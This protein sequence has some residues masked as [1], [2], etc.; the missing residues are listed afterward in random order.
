MKR[1]TSRRHETLSLRGAAAVG[2][3]IGVLAATPALAQDDLRQMTVREAASALQ[4]GDITSSELVE[5]LTEAADANANL[6]AFITLDAAEARAAA[7]EADE[8]RARG[9]GEDMPL[10]GVPLVI[11]DNIIVAGQPTTGGTPALEGFVSERD[12][13]VIARLRDAGAIILGKTNMHELAFGITSD[14]ARFGAVGNAYDPER[15]AGGSSGG[16]GAAVAARLA[17]GGLGTDTG[18]SVRIP[19][20]LNGIAGLRPTMGRYSAAGIVPISHTRDTP[21][22]LARTVDDLV[23]LDGVITGTATELDPVDPSEIRLGIADSLVSGLS[24]EVAAVWNEA[25]AKL[26]GAGVTLVSVALPDLMEL[27]GKIGFPVALYEVARDLPAFLEQWDAGISLADVADQV[28]S[29]DVQGVFGTFV[30]GDKKMPEEVYRAAIETFRPE[31]QALYAETFTANRL[32]ALVFPTTILAAPPIE[33]SGETVEL[34]GEQV[35][36][37]PTYI[38]NTDP[39]SN[40][41]LPGL[42]LPIGLTADGLPVGLELDGPAFT[43]RRLLAIGLGLEDLF[44]SLPAPDIA[45]K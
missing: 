23:L 4:A 7:A 15:S 25:T 34:N 36:T 20:A 9:D 30:M 33:G 18:G 38:R 39:G 32:D 29:P 37:F 28:A 21:G 16:T 1:T 10:L 19:A 44:G 6:N 3:A 2:V 5:A 43:D 12:A 42:T 41:G 13:P 27:N 31:L 40:A 24:P 11:K 14:N 45:T 17:P 8:L 35:P 22:P 26:E